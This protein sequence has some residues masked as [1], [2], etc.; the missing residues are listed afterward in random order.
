MNVNIYIERLILDGVDVPYAQRPALQ[1]ALEA[2]LARL[3]GEGGLTPG[4][5]MGGSFPRVPGGMTLDGGGDPSA[6]GQQIAQ[7]V[8]GGIGQEG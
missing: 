6:L 8:Y 4:L 7:S 2:E 3:I 1:A 5:A